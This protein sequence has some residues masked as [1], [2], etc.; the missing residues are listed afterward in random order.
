MNTTPIHHETAKSSELITEPIVTEIFEIITS[1]LEVH[2]EEAN[3]STAS[4]LVALHAALLV[5]NLGG[6]T[7]QIST[8]GLA[9]TKRRFLEMRVARSARQL[10][11]AEPLAD[12]SR[13]V[14]L[15]SARI[16]QLIHVLDPDLRFAP[17]G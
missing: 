17:Q 12:A 5:Y 2:L 8:R 3:L 9:L 16:E 7:E 11:D 1:E 6:R 4:E 15:A 14:E 10:V 13:I